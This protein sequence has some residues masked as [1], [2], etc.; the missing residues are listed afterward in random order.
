MI[1][2][3]YREHTP[4]LHP[5]VRVG[6]NVTLIGNITAEADVTFWYGTVARGDAGPIRIGKGTNIQDNCILHDSTDIPTEIGRR[7]TVGHGAIL[8]SCKVGDECLIGMGAILLTGCVIGEGSMVAAGALVPENKI[9]PENSVIMGVPARVVRQIT[10][11]ERQANAA[12]AAHYVE[13]GREELLLL[14]E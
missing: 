12:M 7:V 5:T 9:F 8:H 2:K 1:V 3:A 6:E 11:E 14:S 13:R 10:P 4:Q